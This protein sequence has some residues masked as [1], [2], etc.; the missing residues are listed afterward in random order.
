VA[1]ASTVQVAVEIATGVLQFA[2]PQILVDR[3]NTALNVDSPAQ[4]AER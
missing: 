2:T 1:R 3:I 4:A